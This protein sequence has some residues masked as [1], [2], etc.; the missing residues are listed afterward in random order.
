MP[1][2]TGAEK[3][4]DEDQD[5]HDQILGASHVT[6]QVTGHQEPDSTGLGRAPSCRGNEA[7]AGEA[8]TLMALQGQGQ[9]LYLKV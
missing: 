4:M 1:S 8:P 5:G 6:K 7:E 9:S 2:T 3:L